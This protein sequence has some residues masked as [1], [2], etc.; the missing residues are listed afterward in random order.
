[1]TGLIGVPLQFLIQFKGLELTTVSHAALMV[2]TLPV[3]LALSSALFFRERLNGLEWGA[4]SVSALGAGLIAIS[5]AHS[6]H[7]PQPTAKGDLLVL[8]SMVAAVI[9]ILL[10]KRLMAQYDSLQVT[11][12]MIIVGTS[13][14]L[15]WVGSRSLC[16]FISPRKP[17]SR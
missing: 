5:S 6:T 1:L 13:L 11:A 9:M 2:G 10:S 16:T 7:A 8:I 12:S 3:L 17:G 15:I 14:L 4:L